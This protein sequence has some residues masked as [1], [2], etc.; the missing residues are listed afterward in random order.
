MGRFVVCVGFTICGGQGRDIF[1]FLTKK[2]M[3][4]KRYVCW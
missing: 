3:T 1:S 2:W 4:R